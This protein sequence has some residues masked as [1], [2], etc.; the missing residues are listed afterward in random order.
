MRNLKITIEF[1]GSKYKGWQKLKD[2][3][4]TIQGKLENVLS[5]MADEKV[6]L[7]GCGKT[8]IGVHAENYIASFQTS[9]KYSINAMMDY[10]YEFLPE[11]IVVKDIE[12]VN[13]RF[14]A[15]YNRK[16]LTYVYRINN[17]KVRNVFDRKYC[18]HIEGKLNIDEMRNAAEVLVG[19][20]DFQSFT[21]L[22][23]NSKS[24]I[25]TINY[26]DITEKAG[27]IDIEINANDFLWNMANII[28][29]NLLE[30]GKGDMKTKDVERILNNKQRP[31]KGPIAQGKGLCLKEVKY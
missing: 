21:T 10:L 23:P 29:G 22:K 19:T 7:I 15:R 27:R 28:V 25:K 5:K 2:N 24:S 1:D 6:E 16:S 20:K 18:Y 12:E 30:V 14:H 11:D 8:E 3:D 17:S 26:I 4:L 9:C 31:E 13:E